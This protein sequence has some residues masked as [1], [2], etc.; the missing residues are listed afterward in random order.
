LELSASDELDSMHGQPLVRVKNLSKTFVLNKSIV[1]RMLG[2]K[3]EYLRAV[4]DVNLEIYQSEALGLVGESGC[5]KTTLGRCILR[6]YEPDQGQVLM[7]DQNI[8]ELRGPALRQIRRRMQIVFQDPYSSLNPRQRVRV[9]LAE[10]CSV[11]KVCPPAE[12]N[13]HVRYLLNIVGLGPDI[14]DRFPHELSGG[15]RQRV[16]LARALAVEPQFVVADEPVS[17]LDVSIQAQVVNLLMELQEKLHLTL[18]FITHDLRLVHYVSHRV[19]VMYLGSIVELGPSEALF[20][21]PL[22]PYSKALLAALPKVDPRVRARAPAIK[23]E[24]PSPINIPPGCP[25]HPR[26]ALADDRCRSETPPLTE[27]E[28][29][30]LAACL[31]L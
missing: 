31:K 19:A 24:P 14:A 30:R 8:L 5:G 16:N 10:A 28:P 15:Q 6:L 4:H 29:G 1:R 13:D 26:C 22:H 27:K 20:A 9:M 3:P 21:R 12:L 11:H 17:A 2:K 25:F 18:L 7:G 23:G